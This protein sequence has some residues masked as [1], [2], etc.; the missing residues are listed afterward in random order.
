[1]ARAAARRLS[2]PRRGLAAV[3][4]ILVVY[5]VLAYI[6]LPWLWLH[7]EHHPTLEGAPKTTSVADGRPGDPL[8]IGLVAHHPEVVR[9]LLAAGWQPA[10]PITFR[11]SLGIALSVL[12][13]RPDPDAPVSAQYLLGRR[14]D[15][16]FEKAVGHSAR[17][18]HHVRLWRSDAL[19]LG[20][21]PIWLGAATFDRGVGFGHRTAEITHHIAP[22]VDA[23]RDTL[24]TDLIDTKQVATIYGVSGIGPTLWGRNGEGDRYYTDGEMVVLVLEP[25]N[26]A[27]TGPP[28]Q[29]SEPPAV[30]VK[31]SVFDWLRTWLRAFEG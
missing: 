26:V 6:V 7:Y 1:M 10:D 20:G 30:A 27:R 8:N 18:R 28:E 22:D 31:N 23:E 29:L 16:A 15:L 9:G 12:L 24:A 11:S 3:V 14:Q 5:G 25:D 2:W 4:S 13:K 21:R 19:G 17:K